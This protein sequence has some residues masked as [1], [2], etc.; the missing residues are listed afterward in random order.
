MTVI[1]PKYRGSIT[2]EPYL[3]HEMRVT[4]RLMLEE[5]D[6]KRLLDV[7]V[8]ENLFQ[9][10]TERSLKGMAKACIR[11]L[12]S[13]NDESAVRAIAVEPE[14]VA[15]QFCLYALMKDNLI[16]WDFMLTVIGEKYRLNDF[17][18]SRMDLNAFFMRLQEQ[19]DEVATWSDTTI[20]KCKQILLR[21]LVENEY[22]DDRDANRLNP[23]LLCRALENLLRANGEEQAFPAFNYFD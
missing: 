23:V 5:Q 12:N 17:S 1:L 20:A 13:L 19:N 18:F 6:E 14:S 7:I 9:Y 22:I 2:R 16:V 4:A 8:E 10:P 11:R 21:I 3:F 15:Q